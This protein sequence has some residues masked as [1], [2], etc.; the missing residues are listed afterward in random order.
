MPSSPTEHPPRGGALTIRSLRRSFGS[1][2][3]LNDV[4]LEI[5]SGEFFSLLGPSGCGKT[6]LL[7]IIA[8][9]DAPDAGSIL[10]DGEDLLRLPA[11][12]R[13]INTVFQSYA[14]FPHLSVAE[15]IGFGLRMKKI[16]AGEIQERVRRMMD[17]AHVEKLRDRKPHEL[18]GGQRQRVALARALVNEPRVLLLDEPLA[19]VDQ[20]LRAGLQTELRALQAELGLTFI[21][22]T[23]DQEEALKL[24]DRIAVMRVQEIAQV[25]APQEVYDKP[26]NA[27]VA[28]FLGASNFV[29][30]EIKNGLASTPFGDIRF[31]NPHPDGSA[32]LFFRPEKIS[33]GSGPFT[34][35]IKSISFAGTVVHLFLSCGSEAIRATVLRN[36]SHN[37]A[38]DTT[39]AWNI[40]PEAITVFRQAFPEKKT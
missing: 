15:N 20:Q 39:I 24:S 7:R 29:S 4:S 2:V 6:T 11:H 10:L 23:H 12:Q 21:Y 19:A 37:F 28:D 3:A 26:I 36:G 9:L 33:M 30:A 8:G 31:A 35:K 22:V 34:A 16:R 32:T 1:Q 25:G 5:R 38:Q 27:W 18:S 14:L 40:A 13:P 17:L